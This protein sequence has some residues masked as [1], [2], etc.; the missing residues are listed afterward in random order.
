M[1]LAAG[2]L[3]A[4]SLSPWVSY[5]LPSGATLSRNAF[6]FSASH[7]WTWIGPTLLFSACLLGVFGV[8]TFL[9]PF[10]PNLCMPLIPTMIA[11]LEIVD[12]WHGGFGGIAHAT[13]SLG[14]GSFLCYAALGLGVVASLVLIPAEQVL[15]R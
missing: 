10:H 12:I 9:H 5:L 3:A 1:L 2:V 8:L 4:G 6:Q 13:T 11:G 15:T 14:V 7:S